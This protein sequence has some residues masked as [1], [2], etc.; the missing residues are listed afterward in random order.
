M[1]D[2]RRVRDKLNESSDPYDEYD[3]GYCMGW[4]ACLER[5]LGDE[6]DER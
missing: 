2:E 3:T 1:I 5:M 4:D 6:T